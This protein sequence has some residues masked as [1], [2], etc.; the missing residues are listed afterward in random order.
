MNMIGAR[1]K[2]EEKGFEVAGLRR[3]RIWVSAQRKPE[4]KAAEMTRMK[5][6]GEKSTS[7]KTIMTTPTVIV[8]MM[9]MSFREGVSRRKRKA[10]RRTKA[11]AEDLHIAGDSQKE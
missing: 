1:K 6:R 8:A 4:K 11:R 5:P 7:P 10:K 9:A 3:R 2:M